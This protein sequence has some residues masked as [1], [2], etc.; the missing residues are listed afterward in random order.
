MRAIVI[1]TGE[2]TGMEPLSER[3]PVSM[4]P[5][6]DRPFIQHV[7]EFLVDK[8][9]DRFDFILS[10][11]PEKLEEFLGN[12]ARW[13]SSFTYHL[14]READ[15][16]YRTLKS[17]N[18]GDANEQF[19][20]VHADRL[21]LAD[22]AQ[23]KPLPEAAVPRLLC[24]P[25]KDDE[26]KPEWTGWGWLTS[27]CLEHLTGEENEG[28]A[29]AVFMSLARRQGS[30]VEVPKALSLMSYA[31]ILASQKAVL[32]KECEALLLTGTE[33]EEGVRLSRN[34][35]LHPTARINPPVFIGPNCRIGRGVRLGPNAVVGSD[36]VLEERCALED[37]LIFSGSYVGE[38]LD[39]RQ[40]IVDKNRLISVAIGAALTVADNFILGSMTDRHLGRAVLN[41]MSR[42]MAVLLLA[43][44][45]PALLITAL[46]LKV[47]RR[48]PVVHKQ[49]FVKLPTIG[50][51]NEWNT[52]QLFKF[53]PGIHP[54]ASDKAARFSYIR[55]FFLCLLPGLVSMAKG[56]VHFV[57]VQP[58]SA[59]DTAALPDD[60]RALYL[61]SKAG[62]VTE[63]LVI[64]QGTPTEDELY[65]AEAFYSVNAGFAH[66][67]KL[68][69]KYFGRVL[70]IFR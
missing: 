3:Y 63:A 58:R 57:G 13:G 25:G 23:L 38:A 36:S 27:A 61:S 37:C 5:L 64:Y 33:A 28:E 31:D 26:A 48:G 11:L 43:V 52:F 17:I 60:W 30:F 68:S 9:I 53:C 24:L 6:V 56:D 32:N 34:V 39:L 69:L 22:A 14:C 35:I 10:H 59:E 29:G 16:P 66:D 67:L 54:V 15:R 41:A 40:A 49:Q 46:A 21:P 55:H 12:G 19:L 2:R 44:S 1:A 70:N 62:I 42:V 45:W 7:V 18:F 8:V 4:I 50:N 65:S 51:E 47:C 20:L